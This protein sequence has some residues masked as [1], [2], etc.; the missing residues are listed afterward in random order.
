MSC[1]PT[2]RRDSPAG[3]D[4][5]AFGTIFLSI[6]LGRSRLDRIAQRI[7]EDG[8]AKRCR[9][10]EALRHWTSTPKRPLS[11]TVSNQTRL[12]PFAEARGLCP[13][14]NAEILLALELN[15][16]RNIQGLAVADPSLDPLGRLNGRC[17]VLC[18][19]RTTS[20]WRQAVQTN[21]DWLRRL[22]AST[23]PHSGRVCGVYDTGTTQ[24]CETVD[25]SGGRAP[26]QR[27]G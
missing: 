10:A 21:S 7:G 17:P 26:G 5:A 4:M 15:G 16:M 20:A 14:L 19:A 22:V 6:P 2:I 9:T 13:S 24:T 18:C 27:L 23:T 11:S 3:C 8:L 25:F 1:V 12:A